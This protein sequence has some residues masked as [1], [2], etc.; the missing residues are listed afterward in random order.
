MTIKSTII[1]FGVAT[2]AANASTVSISALVDYGLANSSG[3]EL[4]SSSLIKVGYFDTIQDSNLSSSSFAALE[5][6]F[7]EFGSAFTGTGN[8][9]GFNQHFDISI[10]ADSTGFE[11][12]NIYVWVFDGTTVNNSSSHGV[13][14]FTE[15][16]PNQ[17]GNPNSIALSFEMTPPNSTVSSHIGGFGSNTSSA[18]GGALYEMTAIAAVPEPSST[19]LLGLGSVALLLRRR[20]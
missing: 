15:N 17:G 18:T 10:V 12:D 7:Q 3:S 13:F 19:A 14:S 16:F 1:A 2:A 20:R 5:A 9:T 8:A 6:D 4:S 11:N